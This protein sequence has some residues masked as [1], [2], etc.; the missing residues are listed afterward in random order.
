MPLLLSVSLQRNALTIQSADTPQEEAQVPEYI[1]KLFV[2][3]SPDA[4]SGDPQPS[5]LTAVSRSQ[6][7]LEAQCPHSV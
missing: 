2:I 3:K 5:S 4:S 1:A 7:R 6:V